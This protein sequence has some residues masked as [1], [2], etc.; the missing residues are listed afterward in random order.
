[1]VT[2]EWFLTH[3]HWAK[4]KKGIFSEETRKKMS[5]SRKKF[6]ENPQN[7]IQTGQYSQGRKLSK[8]HRE[9]ISL[10]NTGRIVSKETRRKISE[11]HKQKYINGWQPHVGRKHS[12]EWCE[13]QSIAIKKAISEGRLK[14]P[15]RKG[16]SNTPETR[17]KLR[18]AN[19]GKKYGEETKKK[20]SESSKR[21]WSNSKTR[22]KVVKALI[23]A[24]HQKPNGKEQ[25]LGK[26]IRLATKTREYRFN[27]KKAFF[28]IDGLVPDFVNVNGQKKC[29]ELFGD[30]WHDPTRRYNLQHHR[31]EKGR[32]EALAR[33]GW[34]CLVVW[35]RE[36]KEPEKV[37][38]KIR[39][40]N[41]DRNLISVSQGG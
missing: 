3:T 11:K 18:L 17:L 37:I 22:E 28:I 9:Q 1:M 31:T 19:L 32:K 6:Y 10:R 38:E 2:K 8:E 5:E 33:F 39:D 34:D 20:V 41:E 13:K 4:G 29:I 25:V 15:S 27:A 26:L 30:Y 24:S 36:L 14:A 35:E 40:F 12:E 16:L 23:R 7:R 21:M